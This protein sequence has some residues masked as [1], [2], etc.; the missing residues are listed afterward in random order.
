ME[1]VGHCIVGVLAV[2]HDALTYRITWI[3]VIGRRIS[4]RAHV[5]GQRTVEGHV[6]W[7]VVALSITGPLTTARIIVCT[8]LAV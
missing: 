3:K 5:T 7:I 8:V 2:R 6:V 1:I 4:P